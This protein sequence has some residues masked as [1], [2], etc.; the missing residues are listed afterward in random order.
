ME[1]LIEIKKEYNTLNKLQEF[2]TKS[3][4]FEC[5][6]DYDKWDFRI[7]NAGKME[8]CAILKKKQHA[9][10]KAIFYK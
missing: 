8:Q 1:K 6:I 9:R 3:S 7:D 4:S 5:Y 2:L 10:S